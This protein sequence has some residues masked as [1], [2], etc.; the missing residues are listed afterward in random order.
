MLTLLPHTCVPAKCH[1]HFLFSE[2]RI[3]TT[4]MMMMVVV[5]MAVRVSKYNIR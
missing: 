2:E 4:K 3:I 5:V 1:S